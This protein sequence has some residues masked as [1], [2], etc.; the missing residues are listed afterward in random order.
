MK[1]IL[2]YLNQFFGQ[3]G[4][5]DKADTPPILKMEAIGPAKVFEGLLNGEGKVVATFICGDNYMNEHTE[6]SLEEFKKAMNEL[7]PDMVVLGPS[8]NAGR[9]GVATANVAELVKEEYDLPMVS[10]AYNENPGLD[11][12][13][14]SAY[15]A[16][17]K[18]SAASMKEAIETMAKLALKVIKNEK[19]DPEK[20]NYFLRGLRIT[21]F[22]DDIGAKRAVDMLLKRLR[23]ED[24]V[25]EL[26][27]PTFDHVDP[28]KK[29]DD[30]SKATIA[31]V[32]SGG[33]VP[34]GNPDKI[35]SA[36]AQKWG[37][38]N[39]SGRENLQKDFITI[40][41]G[42]DPVYANES[43]DRVVPFDALKE[44][45]K[46]G[47][48]GK[49]YELFYT[50]TGTGTSVANAIKFGQEIGKALKEKNVDGVILTST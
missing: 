2:Y 29:I 15:T 42:Y 9:Y 13:K 5:E 11:I 31:L 18:D 12:L 36:S 4:G 23:G 21:E 50:T 48:I 33:I 37:V 22:S 24:Y 17:T 27:M 26:P 7:K 6:E 1:K 45:E 39:I 43:P 30:L 41:G 3:I 8:F 32:T 14:K 25:T 19:L 44:M 20:D 35:Q 47:E 38:Y 16:K 40:H 49:V 46:A 34:L 28:A 10:G